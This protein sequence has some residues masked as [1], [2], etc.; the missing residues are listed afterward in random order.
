MKPVWHCNNKDTPINLQILFQLQSE[1]F[2]LFL[3]R[4]KIKTTS[5]ECILKTKIHLNT[6]HWNAEVSFENE[7]L[8][9]LF[10]KLLMWA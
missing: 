1:F 6:K 3:L 7:M 5:S 9:L 2:F 10:E 8:V 4:K